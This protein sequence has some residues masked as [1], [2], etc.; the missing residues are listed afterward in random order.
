MPRLRS[1]TIAAALVAAPLFLIPAP[2][3]PGWS[4]PPGKDFPLAGGN[5]GNQRYS[6]LSRVTPSNVAKLGGA[7]MV[8]VTDGAGAGSMEATPV[9]LDGVMYIP[10]NKAVMALDAAT[11]AVK[12]KYA[13]PLSRTNRGVVAAE[14]K[15]FSAGG[16]NTLVAL[17]QK[18]GE[19]IWTAKVGDRGSTAAAAYYYDGLV[20]MGVSGGEG[21]VR[22]FFGAFDAKTGKQVWGFWTIPGPGER[23][24]D[25][26]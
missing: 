24:H 1:M 8:H 11:G 9:V 5:L 3:G 21:G 6:T 26:W 22:G 17:D 13:G 23:G 7:W 20:F 19:L 25:T 15:V 4:A 12:W 16:G 2:A 18:T 10:T 14:G